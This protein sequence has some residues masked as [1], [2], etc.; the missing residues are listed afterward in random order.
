MIRDYDDDHDDGL[1][2]ITAGKRVRRELR[3]C[4]C[5]E[6]ENHDYR[7]W[8]ARMID[9]SPCRLAEGPGPGIIFIMLNP[10]T[11]REDV[12]DPTDRRCQA[13]AAKFGAH[14]YGIVN[15]FATSSPD[16]KSIFDFGYDAAVGPDND[17][18]IA[19]VFREALDHNWPVVCAW[20]APSLPRRW[21]TLVRQ[22]AL[23]VM[24]AYNARKAV[25]ASLP[26]KPLYCLA[27][28]ADLWPRHPLYLGLADGELSC[29]TIDTYSE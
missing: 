16:P 1:S 29:H 8:L 13:F 20:G 21:V 2:L 4:S 26:A 28:T 19:A 22:R 12:R 15:L 23:E 14:W 5:I 27:H 6:S 11:A 17:E 25:A 3:S 7:M 18:V 24:A 9:G 10:S